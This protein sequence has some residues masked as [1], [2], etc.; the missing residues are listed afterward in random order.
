MGGAGV[1]EGA[2]DSSPESGQQGPRASAAHKQMC[3]CPQ[4][5]A[6][7]HGKAGAQ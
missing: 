7:T 4:P 1:G 6:A 2:E 3:P 5:S